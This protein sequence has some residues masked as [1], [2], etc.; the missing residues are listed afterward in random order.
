MPIEE[1]IGVFECG[2]RKGVSGVFDFFII[3]V[4]PLGI[5]LTVGGVVT[6]SRGETMVTHTSV[7]LVLLRVDCDRLVHIDITRQFVAVV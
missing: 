6:T 2:H 7:Q 3:Q 5:V 4:V 1:H